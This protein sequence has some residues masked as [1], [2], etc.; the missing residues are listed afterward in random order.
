MMRL[1]GMKIHLVDRDLGGCFQ[2]CGG[3]FS[4]LALVRGS[5]SLPV[6]GKLFEVP[7]KTTQTTKLYETVVFFKNPDNT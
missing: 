6:T 3:A 7:K 1:L 2:A 4:K 5:K